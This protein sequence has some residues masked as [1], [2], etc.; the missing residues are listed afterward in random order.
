MVQ[1]IPE[2]FEEFK[3]GIRELILQIFLLTSINNF[4]EHKVNLKKMVI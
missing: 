2:R 3:Q 4:L 1:V